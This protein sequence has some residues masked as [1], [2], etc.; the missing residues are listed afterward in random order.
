[1]IER[2]LEGATTWC[3]NLLFSPTGE[4]LSRHRKFQPTAAERVV[5]SQ[6]ERWVEG[7]EDNLPVAHTAIGKIGGLICWESE[8]AMVL[9][10]TYSA[11]QSYG[12]PCRCALRKD[13]SQRRELRAD[14][15][16][17]AIGAICA[18]S[19]RRR[20]VSEVTPVQS[21]NARYVAPTADGRTTWLPTMQHI[22]QEGRCLVVSGECNLV[23]RRHGAE[24]S[25]SISHVTRFPTRLSRQ[26]S[27]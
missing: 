14:T 3:T 8:W 17:H 27:Q 12:E 22:A 23:A 10:W 24:N 19:A 2:S 6:G 7:K 1:V 20:D 25:K 13:C 5:W 9:S 18:V 21:A 26:I 11:C 15:R 4:L 16:L